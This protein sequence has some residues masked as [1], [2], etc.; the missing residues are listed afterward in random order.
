MSRYRLLLLALIGLLLLSC[1]VSL[2]LGSAPVPVEVVWRV[3]LSKLFGIAPQTPAWT[4]GQ[5]H[6]VWL[7]RVP[8]MLRAAG[9]GGGLGGTSVG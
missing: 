6:I 4:T 8:R 3:L 5:E 2:G 7:I 9:V 1:V